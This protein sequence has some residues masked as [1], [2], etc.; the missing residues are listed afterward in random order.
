MFNT[1]RNIAKWSQ[2]SWRGIWE[3]NILGLL[4]NLS[5]VFFRRNKNKRMFKAIKVFT[6]LF[7]QKS[8]RTRY[9]L[10]LSLRVVWVAKAHTITE[11]IKNS[12]FTA[13]VRSVLFNLFVIAEPL[14]YLCVC[15]GTPSTKILKTQITCKKT[16]YITRF[17]K[18]TV[19]SEVKKQE[20]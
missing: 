4:V 16:K 19:V 7:C 12:R 18:Q 13:N 14:I 6:N 5:F 8:L 2:Q 11:T 20:I 3:L 15:H 1:L 9:L 10:A 17:N